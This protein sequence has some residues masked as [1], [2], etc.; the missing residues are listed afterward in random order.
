MNSRKYEM[1]KEI[2]YIKMLIPIRYKDEEEELSNFFNFLKI[3]DS[4]YNHIEI[5]FDYKTG[6]IANYSNFD[7]KLFL[8]ICD[9]GIYFI[10]NKDFDVI[11]E[12]RDCYIPDCIPNEYGDYIDLVVEKGV[13][14]NITS[15]YDF[16]CFYEED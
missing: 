4:E 5:I 2:A 6:K 1:C 16:S 7:F 12:K 13:I 10:L 14:K 9:E 8:K 11:R 15:N 3:E